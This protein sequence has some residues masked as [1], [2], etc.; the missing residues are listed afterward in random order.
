MSDTF[1]FLEAHPEIEIWDN[2]QGTKCTLPEGI[3][4]NTQNFAIPIW[5]LPQLKDRQITRLHLTEFYA[6]SDDESLDNLKSLS[7]TL[8]VLSFKRGAGHG[9]LRTGPL[10]TRISSVVPCIRELQ[11]DYF[12][13][14]L[15]SVDRLATFGVT[16]IDRFHTGIP[17]HN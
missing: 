8:E 12:T 5:L 1:S 16:L 4:P 9:L 6:P 10:I 7:E 15:V 11:I 2:S 3:L 17:F 13:S 14:T